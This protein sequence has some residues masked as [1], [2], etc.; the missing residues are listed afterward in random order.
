MKKTLGI[1]ALAATLALL[2]A[3]PMMGARTTPLIVTPSQLQ[4]TTAPD[5]PAGA[6]MAVVDGDPSKVEHYTVRLMLPDGATFPP[7]YHGGDEMVTVLQGSIVV[8]LGDTIDLAKSQTLPAGSYVFLPAGVH[9]WAR[10]K[11]DA[12][13]QLSGMGPMTQTNVKPG[14]M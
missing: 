8:G 6:K 11:G 3:A 4:W 10:A 13:L 9:H 1:A 5:L 14:S 7:H 12:V 2:G